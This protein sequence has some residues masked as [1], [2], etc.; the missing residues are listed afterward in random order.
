MKNVTNY[1]VLFLTQGDVNHA[2]SR[3]RVYQYLENIPG[4]AVDFGFKIMPLP[5]RGLIRRIIYMLW[6]CFFS[7]RYDVLFIQ[8]ILFPSLLLRF[9]RLFQARL[10]YDWDDALYVRPPIDNISESKQK[11]RTAKLNTTLQLSDV[12]ICGNQVLAEYASN[13]CGDVRVIPTSVIYHSEIP[14]T[15]HNVCCVTIGWIGRAENLYYLKQLKGVFNQLHE[16]YGDHVSLKVVC[17]KQLEIDSPLRVVN[18]AWRLQDEET[19][20]L[21]FDIGIMPLED[22]E[23][24]RGKCAFKLLQYMAL[25]VP[26][27]GSPVGANFEVINHGENGFLALDDSA[28]VDCLSKLIAD[29]VLRSRLADAARYTIKEKFSLQATQDAFL[30]A[31]VGGLKG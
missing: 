1:K 3:F 29:S 6:V 18:K 30:D 17:D 8:K 27:V 25:G 13:Y 26:A 11:K 22:T 15:V 10:V 20:I 21:S 23:W 31:V 7:P 16:Q 19:D 14:G 28:W 12:V 4:A 5:N 9:V 24:A 2:S